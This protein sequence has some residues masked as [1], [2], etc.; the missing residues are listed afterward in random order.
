MTE[1]TSELT[2]EAL[3]KAQPWRA[4]MAWWVVAIEGLLALGIGLYIM[5]GSN[6]GPNIIFL[7]ALFMLIL[8]GER[9][10]NGFRERIPPA[11]LAERMF[12]AGIG[13]TV[14]LII[15]LNA[16]QSFMTGIAAAAILSLGW[17]LIGVVGIWEWI[18]KR[19]QLGIGYTGLIF[20]VMSAVFGLIMLGSRLTWGGL[21]VNTIGIIAIVAGVLLLG[22]AYLLYR[23]AASPAS[24]V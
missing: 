16:W 24:A 5:F 11:V 4:G 17:L 18:A 20:P 21:V 1:Q 2:K 22:Y 14:G 8:N 23:K 3:R 13:V 19:R 6:A 12:V 15:V 10:F 7:L 9:A